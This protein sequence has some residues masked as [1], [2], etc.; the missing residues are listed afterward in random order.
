MTWKNTAATKK[1]QAPLRMDPVA[2][3]CYQP[4]YLVEPAAGMSRGG[5]FF[6]EANQGCVARC[7]CWNKFKHVG[8]S[9]KAKLTRES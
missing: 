9:T 4:C 6:P 5:I 2:L 8:Q 3:L 7:R 1:M